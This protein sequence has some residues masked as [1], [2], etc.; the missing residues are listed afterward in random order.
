MPTAFVDV[1]RGIAEALDPDR[2]Q[3]GTAERAGEADQQQ[4]AVA[5]PGQVIGDAGQD[6]A[7]DIGGGGELLGRQLAG[8]GGFAM[9]AGQGG[10]DV[11]FGGGHRQAGD[12]VQ[13]ADGGTAELDGVDRKPAAALGGEKGDDVGGAGGQARQLVAGH[14]SHQAR[15][16][17]R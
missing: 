16:P 1:L 10:G 8:I 3:F 14:Q 13:G 9:D 11:G 15:T 2:R 7:Q 4:G 5:Q 6:L 17:A 12:E